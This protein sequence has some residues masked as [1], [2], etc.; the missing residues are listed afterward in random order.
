MLDLAIRVG[1]GYEI[2][3]APSVLALL[4]ASV[5]ACTSAPQ[6]QPSTGQNRQVIPGNWDAAARFEAFR[7]GQPL[8]PAPVVLAHD[9]DDVLALGEQLAQLKQQINT[10]KEAPQLEAAKAVQAP[11][12]LKPSMHRR[13]KG[14]ASQ[15]IEPAAAKQAQALAET[16]PQKIN[17]TPVWIA[18]AKRF[19][20]NAKDSS[21]LGAVVR[22]AEISA[23]RVQLNGVPVQPG[24]FPSH[25]VAY[26]DIPLPP[27][28]KGLGDDE[29][30]LAIGALLQ[31]HGHF[32]E[33]LALK[34]AIKSGLQEI[35]IHSELAPSAVLS[36]T[37]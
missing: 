25:S 7:Q 8:A 9:A 6:L 19:E 16:P 31:A 37:P 17:D 5:S 26:A 1:R 23:W 29:I 24:A 15:A 18:A 4:L 33:R 36:P 10:A 35:A 2:R 11:L 27:L 3:V 13:T 12:G 28:V 30:D 34:V 14:Q 21:L 22:W 20:V 32:K